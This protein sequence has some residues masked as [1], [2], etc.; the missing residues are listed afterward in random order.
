MFKSKIMLKLYILGR[1]CREP[2]AGGGPHLGGAREERAEP[3]EG[4]VE[5]GVG[6]EGDDEALAGHAAE[7]ANLGER[8]VRGVG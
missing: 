3:L 2:G 5:G 6:R 8:H 1:R 7:V 4:G